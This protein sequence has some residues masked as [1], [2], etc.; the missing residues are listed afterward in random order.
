M[1]MASVFLVKREA[2]LPADM[3]LGL[4]KSLE[5]C[6]EHQAEWERRL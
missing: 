4:E 5:V 1:P 3:A 6:H 2:K